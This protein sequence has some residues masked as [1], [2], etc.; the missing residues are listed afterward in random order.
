MTAKNLD[1]YKKYLE[2]HY[3]P[4][5]ANL[6]IIGINRYLKFLGKSELRL[7][8]IRVRQ[9]NYLDDVISYQSY[10]LLKRLLK[11]EADQKWY[12]IVWILAATGVRISE[13]V[14]FQVSH[15]AIGFVDI[16]SKGNKIR[17]VYFPKK[18][19]QNYLTGST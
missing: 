16:R 3:C 1:G 9:K 18:Y 7:P 10:L 13:L 17:R 4:R 6:H 19:R 2:T 5:S 8:C 12:Y 15:V 14:Q 11:N